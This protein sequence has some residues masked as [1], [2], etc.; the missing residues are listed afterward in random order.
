MNLWGDSLFDLDL[1]VTDALLWINPDS[2]DDT[3]DA[4]TDVVDSTTPYC[5]SQETCQLWFDGY[6]MMVSV[7]A[8]NW[9]LPYNTNMQLCF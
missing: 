3:T 2:T 8:E 4:T 1:I 7:D 9:A 6:T 5:T